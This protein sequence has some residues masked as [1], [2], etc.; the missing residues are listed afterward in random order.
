MLVDTLAAAG[1]DGEGGSFGLLLVMLAI[2][3]IGLLPI[4]AVVVGSAL[5]VAGFIRR[6]A[7]DHRLAC[8]WGDRST[9]RPHHP[10]GPAP[11]AG[12]PPPRGRD[13][14]LLIVI[15]GFLAMLGLLSLAALALI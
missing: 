7:H 11:Y 9:M 5:L 3:V 1:P 10:A 8:S 14:T 13:G 4:I 2:A 12:V 6:S 15:G